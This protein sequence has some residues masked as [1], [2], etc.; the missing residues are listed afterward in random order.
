MVVIGH[1]WYDKG[2]AIVKNDNQQIVLLAKTFCGTG[3]CA[4]VF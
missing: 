2:G 3:R 4:I 1:A